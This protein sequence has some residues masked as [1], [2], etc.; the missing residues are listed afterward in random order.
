MDP[1]SSN[2]L[3]LDDVIAALTLVRFWRG[4]STGRCP[5]TVNTRFRIS[6][7]LICFLVLLYLIV[8]GD[9]EKPRLLKQRPLWL[10][11]TYKP[12]QSCAGGTPKKHAQRGGT[13]IFFCTPREIRDEL[14]AK[15]THHA[16]AE[17]E[18]NR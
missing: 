13:G 10:S 18:S 3:P 6:Q 11:I 17:W 1:L 8:S 2:G 15:M 4:T 12:D 5:N 7:F 14:E 16:W 9:D